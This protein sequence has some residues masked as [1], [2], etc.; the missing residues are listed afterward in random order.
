MACTHAVT[1]T[2]L[3]RA[4]GAY[5]GDRHVA[6]M[7]SVGARLLKAFTAQI[8]TMRLHIEEVARLASSVEPD[9]NTENVRKAV[10]GRKQPPSASSQYVRATLELKAREPET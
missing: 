6:I 2:V 3:S 10:T 5:G 4:G 1:M 7:A 8:E 9:K